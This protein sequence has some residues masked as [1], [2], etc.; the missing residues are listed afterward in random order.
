MCSARRETGWGGAGGARR[1]Q[2]HGGVS[3]PHD[4][5]DVRD[6]G[7]IEVSGRFDFTVARRREGRGC[8]FRL[9]TWL[10]C[11]PEFASLRVE[12]PGIL[13]N[14]EQI[15]MV[16]L[17]SQRVQTAEL[18]GL[19]GLTARRLTDLWGTLGYLLAR[20]TAPIV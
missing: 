12:S 20:N 3:D 18:D 5:A 8:S 15:D 14:R 10:D 6:R 4:Y 16:A 19:S 11:H 9:I 17:I 13:V 1:L 7:P 2:Q